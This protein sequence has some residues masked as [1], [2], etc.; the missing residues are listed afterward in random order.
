MRGIVL[1]EESGRISEAFR[2]RGWEMWSCDLLPTRGDPR[3]H[4]QGDMFEIMST[5]G[6]CD[7]GIAHPTCTY[8]SNS[9]V[10]WFYEGG[11]S[12]TGSPNLER[13]QAF[14][15]AA[16][17]YERVRIALRENCDRWAIENPVM[18]R[19]ARETIR[20]QGVYFV[21]PWWFGVPELKAT[22]WETHN[23]PKL[24]KRNALLTPKPGTPEHKAWS[25]VHRATPGETRQRDRSETPQG[26]ADAYAE[27]W[28]ATP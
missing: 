11:T 16:K 9:G 15:A 27:Q 18:H 7:I 3:W 12:R 5:F 25:K 26:C 17:H 19:Y 13:W 22:G 2:R 1:G 20:P 23:L 24:Q 6:R 8:L 21:Q 4:I 28:G 14:Y 10:R